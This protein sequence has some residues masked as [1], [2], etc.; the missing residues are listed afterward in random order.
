M[1]KSGLG[2][3]AALLTFT[4][5]VQAAIPY[6]RP[7]TAPVYGVPPRGRSVAAVA[8]DGNGALL[9]WN[10]I[11]R[12]A[13]YAA[14][15]G[16]DGTVLDKTGTRIEAQAIT[17]GPWAFWSGSEYLVFWDRTHARRGADQG[18]VRSGP[19]ERRLRRHRVRGVVATVPEPGVG[20][21]PH[22]SRS[23]SSPSRSTSSAPTASPNCP[24]GNTTSARCACHRQ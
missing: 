15:A 2:L 23:G 6:E 1:M 13:I 12:G 4:C 22:R 24:T 18:H 3:A 16:V 10:D 14:R 19:S 5:A 11:G 20:A 17:A 7:V 8:S 21:E 9:A